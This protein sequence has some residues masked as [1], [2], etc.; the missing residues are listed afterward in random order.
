MSHHSSWTFPTEQHS[1]GCPRS[2]TFVKY[3]NGFLSHFG[4]VPFQRTDCEHT[5]PLSKWLCTEKSFRSPCTIVQRLSSTQSWSYSMATDPVPQCSP[6]SVRLV[7]NMASKKFH[8]FPSGFVSAGHGGLTYRK[9]H[10]P[11]YLPRWIMTGH[12]W[13]GWGSM[14]S[15]P[16]IWSNPAGQGNPNSP[17]CAELM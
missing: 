9:G 7:L 11:S 5:H 16:G 13:W 17:T 6:L 14:C 15:C 1:L 4:L 3:K 10:V 8:F 2:N 12:L